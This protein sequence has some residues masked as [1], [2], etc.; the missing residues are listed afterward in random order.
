MK[1]KPANL[2]IEPQIL[3]DINQQLP[4]KIAKLKEISDEIAKEHGVK[5]G[6][7]RKVIT[8]LYQMLREELL[9]GKTITIPGFVQSLDLYGYPR[10]Q[11]NKL[12]LSLLIRVKT[13]KVL[14]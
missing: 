3:E 11:G 14:R 8:A 2:V 4:I 6:A 10:F 5:K 12:L 1:R 7:T 13:P 9:E